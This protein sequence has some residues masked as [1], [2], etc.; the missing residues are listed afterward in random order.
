MAALTDLLAARRARILDRWTRRIEWEHAPQGLTR[1]EL[2]DHLPH[3]LD[4]LLAALRAGEGKPSVSPLPQESPASASHGTQRLRVGFDVE[5]VVREYGILADILLDELAAT[6]ES[7]DNGEWRLTIR[8][9]STAIA[10]AIAAYVRRRDDELRR[11]AERHVA[12]MAH[13]LRNPLGA[14][15]GATE[16]L[17]LTPGDTSLHGVLDRNL[18]RLGELVDEVLM[19]DRLASRVELQR[20]QVDLAA[21][22]QQAVE[23]AHPSGE[24]RDTKLTLDV[25]AALEVEADRRLLVSTVGNLLSNAVKFTRPGGTVRVRARRDGGAVT[26]EVQD[27]CGGLPSEDTEELFEPFVQRGDE[28]SGFGLGLAIV[29]QAILAHGGRITVQNEPGQGCTFVITLPA[30]AGPR[31]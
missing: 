9:I 13:E 7:L 27:E 14:A 25:G 23:D 19:V 26:I 24:T 16:A 29:R 4:E 1:G 2:W 28:R 10:E 20:E 5:E 8:C 21:L 30:E 31:T 3:I 17:R 12:F 6:G 11:Q 15:R 22:L 18:R